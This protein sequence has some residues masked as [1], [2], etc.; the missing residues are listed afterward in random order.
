MRYCWLF[1]VLASLLCTSLAFAAAPA[2]ARA[3]K[4]TVE[5]SSQ[6]SPPVVGQNLLV[7]TVKDGDKLVTGYGV[8]L[9]IDM[10]TMSMPMDIKATPGTKDGEY[11]A[12]VNLSMAGS[13][14]VAI[15][16]QQM[17][18]MKMAGDG[19]ANFM[20]DT[21]KGITAK[22]SGIAIPWFTVFV[23]LIIAVMVGTIIFYKRIPEKQRGYFIGT[24]TLLI[25]LLATIAIVKKFRDPKTS[26]VLASANMD[27]TTKA[28]PGTVAVTSEIAA[29]GAFQANVTY[30]GTIVPEQE[31]DVSARVTGRLVFMPFYPGDHIA[32]G[33]VIA[34]LDS[35][36][37]AA[38]VQSAASSVQSSQSSIDQANGA[39]ASAQSE[40]ETAQA[41]AKYWEAEIGREQKLYD[42][43][44]ISKDELERE[45][46]QAAAAQAKVKQTQ[47]GVRTAKAGVGVANAAAGQARA[48]L[49]EAETVKNYTE[50]RAS[51]GGIVTARSVAPG[52][53]VQPG[54]SIMKIAKIDTVRI[55]V[56]VSEADVAQIS[57]G[58]SL[59]AHALDTPDKA[60]TANISAVFPARDPSARTAIVEARIPN[61]DGLL[62][63]G[64]YLSVDLHLGTTQSPAI[65]VPTSA[66]LVRNGISS[67]FLA[68]HDSLRVTAKRVTVT[69]GRVSNTRTEI[70]TGV[71]EGDEVITS[72]LTNLHDGDAITI[73]KST[74]L[75]PLGTGSSVPAPPRAEAKGIADTRAVSILPQKT[76]AKAIVPDPAPVEDVVPAA[77]TTGVPTADATKWYHCPMHFDMES[78][79]PGKCPKCGMDYV[80]FAKN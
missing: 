51:Y 46:A 80:L 26:P 11:G 35:S 50:I 61:A 41:D 8:D 17:A 68:V 38:K 57:V 49:S 79:A 63:P 72:G 4:Y 62:N 58:Q 19:V 25:V 66:L 15:S 29:V 27:M 39:V 40:V 56:N 33:Q 44:A 28:A 43:G 77:V 60:I 1:I 22:G 3:G 74:P 14:K 12:N 64:Q 78:N 21:G 70:L 16:V 23:V 75:M 59:T 10:T 9:H 30:T 76:P 53:L 18:G 13:W 32:A 55:Q 6:P 54:T 20:I 42:L 2:T 7:I 34:N 31:E 48:Q 52:T 36:E 69:A 24:L 5:L 65:T 37:L 71:K 73:L 47:A 45:T 67:V